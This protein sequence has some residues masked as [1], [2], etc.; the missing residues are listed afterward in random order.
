MKC[1]SWI[2]FITK[3]RNVKCFRCKEEEHLWDKELV[4]AFEAM[5][6]LKQFIEKHQKCKKEE[7]KKGEELD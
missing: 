4:N 5:T 1:P 2:G 3:T 7:I 6:V